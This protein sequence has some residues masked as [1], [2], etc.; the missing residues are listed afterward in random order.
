MARDRRGSTGPREI[1]AAVA[2]RY[3]KSRAMWGAYNEDG[4]LRVIE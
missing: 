4:S 3:S 1:T 2:A